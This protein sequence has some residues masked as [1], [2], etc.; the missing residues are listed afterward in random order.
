MLN[1]SGKP[2]GKWST[3][4]ID[5]DTIGDPPLMWQRII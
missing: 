5:F 4:D 3:H 1:C 2:F